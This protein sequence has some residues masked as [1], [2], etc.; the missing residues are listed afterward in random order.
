MNGNAIEWAEACWKGNCG[1]RVMRGGSR[2][3]DP[4]NLRSTDLGGDGTGNQSSR[5]GFR[6]ARTLD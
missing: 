1:R 2:N 3:N 4:E 5:V 6:M